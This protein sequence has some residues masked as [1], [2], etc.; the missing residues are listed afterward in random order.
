MKTIECDADLHNHISLDEKS[1]PT[2]FNRVINYWSKKLGDY[3][4][5][6]I[7]DSR[8]ERKFE[9]FV[10]L[11]GYERR[12][13]GNAIYIPEKKLW[14]V[15]SQEVKTRE[16]HLLI[17]GGNIREYLESERPITETIDKAKNKGLIVVVPHAAG[18]L[19]SLKTW[20]SFASIKRGDFFFPKYF[21][22]KISGIEIF[23]AQAILPIPF[24]VPFFA[25]KKNLEFYR[26]IARW[27]T[28][29][30]T[31]PSQSEEEKNN[32]AKVGALAC[33]D[34][35]SYKHVGTSYT[36]INMPHPDEI[37]DNIMLNWYLDG[38]IRESQLRDKLVW[39][40]ESETDDEWGYNCKPKII[41]RLALF[42][43]KREPAK[44]AALEHVIL[45][46][47]GW[48]WRTYIKGE[49]EKL[50]G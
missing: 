4:I 38:S 11:P 9:R 27:T 15:R 45:G 48:A 36:T 31:R 30:P 13:L 2:N 10:S 46:V 33:S 17:L 20:E 34:G 28:H 6:S 8:E 26:M 42:D 50:I 37:P 23:N 1:I 16:G 21:S 43:G 12:N 49:R 32:S 44:L 18:A 14:V 25:N 39:E 3:G 41:E 5:V 19:G 47:G 22:Q 29:A 24:V 40:G 35:R 7:T